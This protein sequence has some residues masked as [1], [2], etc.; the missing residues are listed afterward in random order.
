MKRLLFTAFTICMF[1]NNLLAQEDNYMP[2]DY[3]VIAEG[4]DSPFQNLQIVC[5]NKYFNREQL[6]KA[7]K[8]KYD[9]ANKQLFKK[10]MLVQ[11]FYSDKDKIGLDKFEIR[12][13][14]ESSSDIIIDYHLVNSD[15]TNDSS[16]QSPFIVIQI[17]KNTKKQIRFFANGKE[18]G[19]GQDLYIDN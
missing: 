16:I 18:L 8:D 5:F 3:T 13:V 7:F 4:N 1:T 9:L 2:I 15:S 12:E 10:K 11:L 19:K 17:P 14:K 6:P